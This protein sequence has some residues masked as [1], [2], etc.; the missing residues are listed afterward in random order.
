MI[1]GAVRRA[2]SDPL[3]AGRSLARR[4][5]LTR[6]KSAADSIFRKHAAMAHQ[7]G[8]R[9]VN[10]IMS[11][12]CDTPED[13]TAALRLFDQ[14]EKR[15]IPAAFAVPG[16]MLREAAEVY[17]SLAKRGAAFLNHG[18]L[19]HAEFRDGRYHA[20]T[21]YN[22]MSDQQVVQDMTEGHRLVTEVTGSAPRGFRAPHFGY[23]QKPEQRALVYRVAREHRY[24]FCSDTLPATGYE[25]GPIFDVG[26][27]V[28]IPL[29]GSYAD[30]HTILDSWNYL[31]D[32][33]NFRLRE[34]YLTL[35][36]QTVDFFAS[37]K[38][39]ALLNYY[40]DPAHV[41]GSDTFINAIDHAQDRGVRFVSFDQ[42]IAL[43][44]GQPARNN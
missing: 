27:L 22:E 11:Y 28:E 35:F 17:G 20:L 43:S 34:D 42:L 10:V 24:A 40:V 6:S 44:G 36:S 2:L 23:F 29:S 9:G 7:A 41:I 5:N 39:P 21:F 31:A 30:P 1:F 26:G 12:D 32:V 25:K 33:V 18:A 37:R 4:M 38:L 15:R 19:P 13:A 14:L 16:A 3:A 8:L